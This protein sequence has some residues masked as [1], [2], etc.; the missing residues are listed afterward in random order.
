MLALD[1]R[2][3]S[4][5]GYHAPRW[6]APWYGSAH[7]LPW[8]TRRP[9]LP[10]KVFPS[11]N[12]TRFSHEWSLSRRNGP[13]YRSRRLSRNKAGNQAST[14]P[15][16]ASRNLYWNSKARRSGWSRP[17]E[18]IP[19]TGPRA[20]P[21]PADW[22]GRSYWSTR[23]PDTLCSVPV[24]GTRYFYQS[25]RRHPSRTTARRRRLRRIERN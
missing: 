1:A 12:I 10:H 7:H 23:E 13:V 4:P 3:W 25:S 21:A 20:S 8:T 18:A 11:D 19:S 5:S 16:D 6:S 17:S 9:L 15:P 2:W 22:S 14:P 24:L